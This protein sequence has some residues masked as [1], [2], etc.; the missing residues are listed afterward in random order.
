MIGKWSLSFHVVVAN[1]LDLGA[2]YYGITEM[3]NT[4]EL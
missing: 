3:N 4:D 2:L 1:S